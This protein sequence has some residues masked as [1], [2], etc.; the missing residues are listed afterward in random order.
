MVQN[1]KNI[2]LAFVSLL[3]SKN[4][5]ETLYPD[6]QGN[7]YTAFQTNE[8]AI[9]NA[10]RILQKQDQQLDKVYL[11]ASTE[12]KEKNIDHENEFGQVT[13]LE[14]LEKRLEKEN[15]AFAGRMEDIQYDDKSEGM[16]ESLR[17]VTR[18]ASRVMQFVQENKNADINVYA[19]MTGG[20]RHGSMM[21]LDVLQILEYSGVHLQKV[22]YTDFKKKKVYDASSLQ[23]VTHL[24]NGADEFVKFGSV[25]G[26]LDYFK[27]VAISDSLQK[28]LNEMRRFSEA[29]HICR[30]SVIKDNLKGLA[31]VLR[32]FKENHGDSL[33]EILFASLTEAIERGYGKLIA[34][35]PENLDIIRWCVDKGFLQ[36]AMTLCTEW[37][38][39]ELVKRKITYTDDNN[40]MLDCK[41]QNDAPGKSWQSYLLTSYKYSNSG[42]YNQNSSGYSPDSA[43]NF[44][45]EILRGQLFSV[46][47]EKCKIKETD[48]N[49]YPRMVQF[50][51]EYKEFDRELMLVRV[52]L[53][54][55]KEFA[56][57]YPIM[58]EAIESYW[59]G[60]AQNPT[61]RKTFLEFLE[62]ISRQS[63][64]KYILA[65]QVFRNFFHVNVSVEDN[66]KRVVSNNKIIKGKWKGALARYERLFE[67]HV[68]KTDYRYEDMI[69]CL[70]DFF[71]IRIERNQ[72][73]HANSE[74][75]LSY[76][77]LT[78]LINT[79]LDRIESLTGQ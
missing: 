43:M 42:Y 21:M 8:A 44:K 11:L 70:Y 28:L 15:P 7:S 31:M 17:S 34:G 13:T 2:M 73:N 29:I 9:V 67:T 76:R 64:R 78:Q 79:A 68:L 32:A 61:Y 72:I 46:L 36:Q 26:L 24:I 23:N 62:T 57:K 38:P 65:E 69:D 25:S 55:F 41:Q 14:F 12:V 37:L 58:A 22:F 51:I 59:K 74:L 56:N 75:D 39:V 19:D 47:E 63:I 35:E 48:C 3:G 30:T 5:K 6:L 49:L 53:K 27:G 33:Q 45:E 52:G 40:V 10:Q 71:L 1:E 4:F 50:C 20:F 18:I 66:N 54:D 16:E 60:N 77:N